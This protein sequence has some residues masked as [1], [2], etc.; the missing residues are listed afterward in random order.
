MGSSNN[1][2]TRGVTNEFKQYRREVGR[3]LLA[4]RNAS[5]FGGNQA[6]FARNLDIPAPT[7]GN[8][9]TGYS[10]PALH[11][12]GMIIANRGGV[13]LDYI[14]RGKFDGIPLQLANEL[15]IELDKLPND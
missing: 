2:E 4:L 8:Y 10:V 15:R 14:Y 9:E 13:T 12:Y 5:G 7:Y 3:R 1:D 6:Q 11:P